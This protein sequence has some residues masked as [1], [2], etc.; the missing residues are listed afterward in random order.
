MKENLRTIPVAMGP[1]LLLAA[2]PTQKRRK[3]FSELTLV[4]MII[5]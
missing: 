2:A 4:S 1:L 3:D 5:R